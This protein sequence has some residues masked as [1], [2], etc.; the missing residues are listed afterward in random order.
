MVCGFRDAANKKMRLDVS[1]DK[2]WEFIYSQG[3]RWG[4]LEATTEQGVTL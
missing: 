1:Q 2:G 4:Y 3:E